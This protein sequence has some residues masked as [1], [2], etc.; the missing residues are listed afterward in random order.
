MLHHIDFVKRQCDSGCWCCSVLPC[1]QSNLFSHKCWRC[2]PVHEAACSNN[3]EKWTW[4]KESEWNFDWEGKHQSLHS[5]RCFWINV[6]MY[7]ISLLHRKM[8]AWFCHIEVRFQKDI[9]VYNLIL[10]TIVET[11]FGLTQYL[12]IL[13]FSKWKVFCTTIGVSQESSSIW[14]AVFPLCKTF[15][16]F[17]SFMQEAESTSFFSNIPSFVSSSLLHS[18]WFKMM[19]YSHLD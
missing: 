14:K 12:F 8:G 3:F 9:L 4:Y 19:I 11:W 13:H 18:L 15:H 5:G 2:Y 7:K 17:A 10:H 6:L 16:L 1:F